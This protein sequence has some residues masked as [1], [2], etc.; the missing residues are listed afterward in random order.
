MTA[1]L[2]SLYTRIGQQVVDLSGEPLVRAFVH[3]EMADDFGSVGL[4]IDRGDGQFV[5]MTDEDAQLYDLFDQLRVAFRAAGMGVWSQATFTL[6]SDASFKVAF[7][8]GDISDL[9]ESAARRE[10]WMAKTLGPQ[11]VVKWPEP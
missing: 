3:V 4:F 9:G 2:E 5:Y 10:G 8:Y 7:G 11:V 6:E 1:L